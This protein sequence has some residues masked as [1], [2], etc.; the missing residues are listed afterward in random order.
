MKVH[1]F[2]KREANAGSSRQRAFLV[3][4]QLRK[5]GVDADIHG[6]SAAT[7]SETSWP[8]KA[9]LIWGHIVGLGEIRAGD[10]VFLQR[11][12]GNKYLLVLLVLYTLLFRRK[13]F[14]DMDDSVFLS[15]PW[16]TKLF[17]KM[18][19]VI[20]VGSHYLADW[21]KA[22]NP[23]VHIIP[24]SVSIEKYRSQ[25][26]DY[27]IVNDTL[28]IGWVGG[29]NYHYENLRLLAPAFQELVRRGVPFRF[30]LIGASGNQKVYDLF[31]GI[32]GLD[33]ELIDALDWTDPKAVPSA[34]QKFDIGLMPLV[35]TPGTRGKCAFKAIEYMACGVVPIV[36]P[37]GENVHLVQDGVNGF[38]AKD[39]EEW[40]EKILRVQQDP[41]LCQ[42]IGKNAQAT[43]EKD[44]SFDANMGR[45]IDLFARA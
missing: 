7:I 8:K 29:A 34:I 43:I 15:L 37:V 38:L 31:Q 18:S 28:T 42:T 10:I 44:Y 45:L 3:V 26:R 1:F 41:G 22:Y 17:V 27:S 25:S 40:V 30:V 33:V 39:T 13:T 14:F 11:P 5:K 24:T 6:P 35:D 12:L 19:D 20:V 4:D 23:N 2:T 36:S 9:S 16:K 21:A 32:R